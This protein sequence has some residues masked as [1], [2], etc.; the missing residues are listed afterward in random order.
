MVASKDERKPPTENLHIYYS[1][2]KDRAHDT[3]E[4]YQLK[5]EIKRLIH[6]DYLR[7]FVALGRRKRGPQVTA[8]KEKIK[9]SK[10]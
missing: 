1:F 3:E 9:R 6:Q 5:D 4:Y 8:K 2:H 7:E 10:S